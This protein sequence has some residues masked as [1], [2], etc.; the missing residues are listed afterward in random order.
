P[1]YR[2]ITDEQFANRQLLR[3]IIFC[4]CQRK[5]RKH[6]VY[7]LFAFFENAPKSGFDNYLTTKVIPIYFGL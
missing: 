7:G 5:V 2:G 1:S 3:E 4:P 6:A